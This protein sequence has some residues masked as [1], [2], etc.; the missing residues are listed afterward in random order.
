MAAFV[1]ALRPLLPVDAE[2]ELVNR[3]VAFVEDEREV[4]R[5]A[6]VCA[7]F[8]QSER[9]C[10]A[11]CTAGSGSPRSGSSSAG[12]CRRPPS[13]SASGAPASVEVAAALGYA[14]QPHLNR[15]FPRVT[16]MTPGE[17]A[18]RYTG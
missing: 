13:A 10:S 11:W 12:A 15:D 2:G 1:D 16:G 3:V 5:V 7:R 8:G 18:A 6:Q 4:T 9:R 14:D 17:F